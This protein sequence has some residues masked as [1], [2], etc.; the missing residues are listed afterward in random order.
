MMDPAAI[1]AASELNAQWQQAWANWF[2]VVGDVG[3]IVAA[4]YLGRSQTRAARIV[5]QDERLRVSRLHVVKLRERLAGIETRIAACLRS[6]G[7]LQVCIVGPAR[8]D[9]YAASMAISDYWISP[10]PDLESIVSVAETFVSDVSDPV[11]ALVDAIS[12]FH[13][14]LRATADRIALDEQS[15]YEDCEP[16]VHFLRRSLADLQVAAFRTSTRLEN[17]AAE[18]RRRAQG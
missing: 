2:Q 18:Q 8:H 16:L 12:L 11:A 5:A 7:L 13:G 9:T 10:L 14:E 4:W 15:R 1:Q 6:V 3:A 17:F